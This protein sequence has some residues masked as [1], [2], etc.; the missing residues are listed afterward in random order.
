M[1]CLEAKELGR[2]TSDNDETV[3]LCVGSLR[4]GNNIVRFTGLQ[5]SLSQHLQLDPT[6]GAVKLGNGTGFRFDRE[7]SDSHYVTVE[8]KDDN[9]QGNTNTVELVVRV[10][11]ANDN[12]PLFSAVEY[13]SFLLENSPKFKVPLVVTATDSDQ[14]GTENAEVRFTIVEGDPRGNFTVDSNTGEI[15]PN[16]V[17]DYEQMLGDTYNLTVRAF[18]LG[19]P[20]LSADVTVV[21]FLIDQNDNP[22]LFSQMEYS[23]SIPEDIAGLSPVLQVT[24]NDRDGSSP[25][26]HIVYRIQ[27]GAKDK[28]V[29]NPETGMISVSEGAN[30]DPDLT[31]PSITQYPLEVVAID[32][33]IGSEKLTGWTRVTINITDVNNKPPRFAKIDPVL[34]SEDATIGLSIRQ[35]FALDPDSGAILRYSLN[36]KRSEARSGEGRLIKLTDYDWSSMFSVNENTGVISVTGMLD[37]EMIAEYKLEV[38]VEDIAADTRKPQVAFSSVHVAVLD[39]NDNSPQFTMSEYKGMVSEN[40]GTGT[41]IMTVLATD[42][43]VNRTI[44]YSL[45]GKPRFSRM[46]S[47]DDETGEI[48]VSGKIDREVYDWLN[49][50]VGATDSGNP[51]K[52]SFASVFIQV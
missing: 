38:I 34:V 27:S 40:S 23:V 16:G 29:I 37:R 12:A 11:D 14:E 4:L 31:S 46:V 48:F 35:L 15:T 39:V 13:Q 20:S 50:T 33:G 9:G 5:G 36:M 22:P 47:I 25:N 18:D 32:G 3:L 42:L 17:L 49:L 7:K 43:D 8:V 10:R 51:V 45:K 19:S 30:L 28:F 52:T 24:A 6:T 26:N 2:K 1:G 44:R 41:K 21:I